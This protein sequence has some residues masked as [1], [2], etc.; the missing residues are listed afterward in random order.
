MG[1][2]RLQAFK[3]YLNGVVSQD[4]LEYY[5]ELIVSDQPLPLPF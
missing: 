2:G 4:K 5:L 3:G 1:Q